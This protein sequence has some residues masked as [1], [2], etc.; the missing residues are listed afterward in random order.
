MSV[1]RCVLLA[2]VFSWGFTLIQKDAANAQV[3]KPERASLA[4][5]TPIVPDPANRTKV[6]TP[7]EITEAEGGF[8]SFTCVQADALGDAVCWCTSLQGCRDLTA[9]GW[10]DNGGEWWTARPNT[11]GCTLSAVQ[12]KKSNKGFGGK[13]KRVANVRQ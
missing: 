13:G 6:S 12:A 10:C 7:D 8:D 5:Q 1:F 2:A 9:S 11:L 3:K 4:V